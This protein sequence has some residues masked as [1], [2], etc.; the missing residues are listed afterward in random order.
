MPDE[1]DEVLGDG[2]HV[3][4]VVLESGWRGEWRGEVTTEAVPLLS[5]L[6]DEADVVV[7]LGSQLP[8]NHVRLVGRSERIL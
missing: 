3:G 4:G 8:V 2:V 1:V 5:V 6:V 7:V